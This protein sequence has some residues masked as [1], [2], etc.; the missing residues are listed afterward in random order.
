MDTKEMFERKGFDKKTIEFLNNFL[1]E[2][3]NLY[4]SFLSQEDVLERIKDYLDE[5]EFVDE[6]RKD[7][8]VGCYNTENKRIDIKKSNIEEEKSVF[9][10]E[11]VHV[12]HEKL[13][14][15]FKENCVFQQMDF[16]GTGVDEGFTAYLTS[17]RD[18]KFFESKDDSYPI[19]KEQFGFLVNIVGEEDLIKGIFNSLEQV[20]S[21]L[22]KKLNWKENDRYDYCKA[23]TAIYEYED[24]ILAKRNRKKGSA[25]SLLESIFGAGVNEFTIPEEVNLAKETIVEKYLMQTITS[26]EDF[27]ALMN[28]MKIYA[29][30]LGK[31]VGEEMIMTL[32]KQYKKHP[33]FNLEE[34][35]PE[36][37]KSFEIYDKLQKFYDLSLEE[38]FQVL[39]ENK[40]FTA[41]LNNSYAFKKM[42]VQHMNE[43]KKMMDSDSIDLLE[44][45]INY[46]IITHYMVCWSADY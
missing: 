3:N 10:H 43:D 45:I 16:G 23:M 20:N 8:V 24:E 11:M 18:E 34:S 42:V 4:G 22:Q 36:L 6:M 14:E 37:C 5:V 30:S 31:D 33:E 13:D 25:E 44:M 26:K 12:L 29:K 19:L 32:Y 7:E 35:N 38:K 40:E 1:Y 41:S 9:F 15:E 17:K 46:Q 39:A 2:F 21:I 28:N 27:Y